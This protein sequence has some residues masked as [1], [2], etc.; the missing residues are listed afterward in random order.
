M[1]RV[2]VICEGQTEEE[3]VKYEFEGLLFSEPAQLAS[4]IGKPN[5]EADFGEI[6][7]QFST[8]EWI[9]DSPQTAPSK[10]I[11][12]LFEGYDKPEHP[13]LAVLEIGLETIRRECLLFDVWIKRLETLATGGPT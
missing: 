7:S 5:L 12:R 9:N 1:I 2:H 3:F 13:L 4:S 6:R 8:P 11:Q 10:R